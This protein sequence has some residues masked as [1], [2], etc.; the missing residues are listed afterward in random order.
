MKIYRKRFIPDELV[1]ISSDEILHNDEDVIIT[2]WLPIKPRL[3]VG[4][5]MSITFKKDG[6]K[7]SKFFDREGNFIYWY[8]DIVQYA[9][10]ELKDEHLFIDLL[11]DVKADENWNYE[12]IDLDE[13]AMAYKLNLITANILCE[14]LEKLNKLLEQIKNGE[15]TDKIKKYEM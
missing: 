5:G 8:C 4:S 11:V 7:V 10:N 3:D 14:A 2:K 6:I 9:Y 12:V 1:D 15:I 13:L